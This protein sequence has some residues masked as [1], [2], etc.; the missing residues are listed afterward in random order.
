MQKTG[1]L[2]ICNS[3]TIPVAT[4]S[5][6]VS[7][8]HGGQ[9]ALIV[10]AASVAQLHLECKNINGAWARCHSSAIAANVVIPLSAPAGEYRMSA[11]GSGAVGV[12]AVLCPTS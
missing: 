4:P 2:I 10:T 1:V 11:T 5:T 6:S 8:W 3:S 7:G 12:H 9:A